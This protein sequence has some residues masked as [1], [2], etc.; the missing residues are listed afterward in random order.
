VAFDGKGLL[1]VADFGNNRVV[2]LKT[3]DRSLA[4]SFAVPSPDWLAVHPGTGAVYVQSGDAVIK[5]NNGQAVA[6]LS[7]PKQK[8]ARWRLTLDASAEPPVIWAGHATTLV[9]SEDQG[10][11][12]GDLRPAASFAPRM[13][14]R[15]AADPTKKLIACRIGGSWGSQL[16]VLEEATGQV[17][18][19]GTEVAGS[20]GRTHRLGPDGIIFAVDHGAGVIRYDRAGKVS[21]FP[22]T[23]DDPALRG[24]LGAGNTGT[25]AWER[26]FWV[27][28][29]GDLYVRKAGPEYHGHMTLE[30]FDPDGR[31]RRTALW[32]VSDAMYGPRV[33]AQ[34]NLF[35]MDMIKPLGEP[36]PK[37]FEGRLTTTRTPHWY[38]WIYGS[39]IKFGPQGGALWFADDGASP[40]SFEGWRV[41]ST[42][43]VSN[44]RTTGGSLRGDISKKPA[45]LA[46]P[47]G[48]LDA[49]A[50][51]RIVVRLKNDSDG[52]QATLNWSVVGEPYGT[53]QRRKSIPIQPQSDFTEYTFD[54]SGEKEWK[55]ATHRRRQGQL[56]HR[57]GADPGR[58]VPQGL[59]LRPG[60]LEG[61]QAAG[62][63]QEGGGRR[64]YQAAGKHPPGRGVVAAGVLAA[65]QGAGERHLP[66]HSLGFRHGRLRPALRPGQW[67]VPNRG[68]RF[69]R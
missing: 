36:Y 35:I 63:P 45:Q 25:T 69:E 22:A 6:R 18:V 58:E 32:T 8:D 5:F 42:N 17:R 1:F 27:D 66:L 56:Q 59:E 23:A 24:R 46:A 65:R 14:W 34:G 67:T 31:H 53:A 37:E 47:A 57:L 54:L 15:P 11:A 48:G 68:P 44:L 9:R 3:A 55:G 40:V 43:S 19:Y 4:G 13:L 52:S 7:L 30:V 49:A 50:Q 26:D 41:T 21:P 12:F 29:R 28:R 10:A 39:V 60:G 61:D 20:E 51:T 2:T 16:H 64:L 33:D 62:D 38:N